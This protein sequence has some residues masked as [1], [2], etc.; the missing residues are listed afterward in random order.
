MGTSVVVDV[1]VD[2][3]VDVVVDVELGS[4]SAAVDVV[5]AAPGSIGDAG[6]AVGGDEHEATDMTAAA[7]MATARVVAIVRDTVIFWI[8]GVR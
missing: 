5:S 8:R 6:P 4:G 7:T 2:V 1:E 3:E